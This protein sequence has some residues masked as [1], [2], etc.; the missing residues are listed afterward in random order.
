MQEKLKRELNLTQSTALNM[1]D[2]VGIGPFIV[3]PLVIQEMNGPQAMLAW[4]LGAVL[5]FLDGFVWAELGAA[6]PNAGGTYSFLKNIYG[7]KSA[8]RYFS[9]L[10][11]WQTII[12]APLVVASGAIG[13]AQYFTYLAPI[14]PLMQKALSG[15]LVLLLV[16][17]LYRRIGEVGQISVMLW[18]GVVGTMVWIIFG[19]VTH[20]DPALAFD[21]PEGAFTFDLVFFAA[22]GSATIKTIYTYLGYYN[23]CHLGSEVQNPEKIIPQS[24]FISIAGIAVLYLVMQMSFFGVIH[25][26]EIKN[27]QFVVSLFMERI[28]GT[29]A[30]KVVTILILWIAF[31]SL[32]AVLVGYTRI[33][34]A[35]AL[36]GNFF[37]VFGE[38]HPVKNFP[39]KS[40]L[41]LGGIAFIFSLLFRLKDVIAAILAMRILVQFVNQTIGLLY[42]HKKGVREN[43][44]YKMPLFPIPPLISLLVWIGL[45]LSTGFNFIAGGL[46][47]IML[48]SIV[49]FIRAYRQKEWP[50]VKEL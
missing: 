21:F 5:S 50:F 15:G 27:S 48:G 45:F 36:D 1:I 29:T 31:S 33:P 18:I 42:L 44:P 13:F 43:F 32:F 9:F 26:E 7:E 30:A 40:L 12:Q 14:D 10:F 39:H 20:F 11:I 6:Y 2:M 47:M 41:I 8:G 38:V 23:V 16:F 4:V 25:W 3:V 37:K 22:L 19:G 49:Y 35:A 46:G 17:L 24:M 34:Y 28:Y